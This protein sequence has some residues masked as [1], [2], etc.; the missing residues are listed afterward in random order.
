MIVYRRIIKVLFFL[1]ITYSTSFGQNFDPLFIPFE[2]NGRSLENPL[3]GGLLAPQFVSF[4]LDGQGPEDLLVLERNGDVLLPFINNSTPGN[5]DYTFAPEYIQYFPK[6]LRFLKMEDYNNDGKK[7]IFTLSS[8]VFGFEVWKNVSEGE[9]IEFELVE[10]NSVAGNYIPIQAGEGYSQLYVANIDIPAV[11]DIDDDGDLDILTFEQEGSF[12]NY[13]Q[14]MV[15]ESGLSPDTMAYKLN[16]LCWGKFFETG[17]NE[18]ILLSDDRNACA[19][20]MI[21][22][23]PTSSERHAGSTVTVFD[24]DGDGDLDLLLGDIGNQG[25]VFLEND[26]VDGKAFMV[27]QDTNF[28]QYDEATDIYIFIGSFFIDIDNDGKRDLITCPN[29][30]LGSDN[31]NH[32][33]Y[34]RNIGEDDAPIF[35]LIQKDFL[36]ETTLQMGHASMPCFLD[37]NQDGLLDLL[38][39]MDY[40]NQN[41]SQT[42]LSLFLYENVG[43]KNEPSYRLVSND[44]LGLRDV[45]PAEEGFLA[46]AVGDLD[47][48]GDD[49]I[50][51]ANKESRILYFE[52]IAGANQPYE[53][54]NFIYNFHN[55]RV[56]S[57]GKPA[58]IDLDED[59]L[60][61]IVIGEKNNNG[62]AQT[63]DK[64]SL[65]FYKNIGSIG[66]PLF[67]EDEDVHPNTS[68]LGNVF[69]ANTG[70]STG[71][72]APCFFESEGELMVAVGSRGGNLYLYDDIYGNIYDSFNEI[73]DSLPIF[74]L[75]KRT[76]PAIADIDNDGYHEMIVG[77]DSGGLWAFNTMI[78][79]DEISSTQE[80]EGSGINIYPNP[81]NQTIQVFLK[82]STSTEFNIYNL[83]GRLVGTDKTDKLATGYDVSDLQSGVYILSFEVEGKIQNERFVKY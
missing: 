39:G 29:N 60:A 51:V 48:D 30:E 54:E 35:E 79:S 44:Y 81:T 11:V 47:G 23:D 53:F 16:D 83:D 13:Y 25:L 19:F 10:F 52:N 45:L 43:S 72:S 6:L 24:S 20:E 14:N 37:Y 1:I 65:N 27:D 59:G 64:G 15:V 75:G 63:E 66:N 73:S 22:N 26:E 80:V 69:T 9:E 28:P 17:S 50:I 33:W 12:L 46:P 76:S 31:V 68:T 67:A 55:I 7:D 4:D 70:S 40:I 56:G 82:E 21:G 62:N 36:H 61:D 18:T 77:N 58:I 5:P 34:Y 74:R 32:I 2:V 38:V 3:I 8:K 57:N 42:S 71:G 49:D 41:G 78:K